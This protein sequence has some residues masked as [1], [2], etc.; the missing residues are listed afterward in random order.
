MTDVAAPATTADEK[1]DSTA[2]KV[3]DS[4]TEAAKATRDTAKWIATAFAAIPALGAF[5]A[6]VRAPGDAGFDPGMLFVGI[7]FAA[8]AVMIG[9][10][11]IASV[12]APTPMSD[13]ALLDE[14][15]D[16]RKVPGHPFS[17]Y[18]GLLSSLVSV[19]TAYVS[20]ELVTSNSQA[21][22]A[23]ADAEAARS[24]ADVSA[25]ELAL[26]EDPNNERLKAALAKAKLLRDMAR[27]EAKHA[28]NS[29]AARDVGLKY[30]GSQLEARETVRARA[31]ELASAEK[32]GRLYR[33][34]LYLLVVAVALGALAVLFLALA[35]KPKADAAAVTPTLVTITLNEAGMTALSCRTQSLQAVRVGGTDQVPKL[36]TF[37]TPECPSRLVEFTL[38]Q[39]TSLGTLVTASPAVPPSPTP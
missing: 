27:G 18:S 14:Q 31:L 6:L 25:A 12:I 22:K 19:R 38:S 1:A 15:F 24:E 35:P 10:F 21:R 5:G 20:E 23:M 9:V 34:A 28:T 39:P 30:L 26:L 29:A 13:R 17:T 32:V 3:V 16:I 2:S 8:L 4:A 37:P 7:V 11:G 36:I 33:E